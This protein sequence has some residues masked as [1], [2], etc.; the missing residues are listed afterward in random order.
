[1]TSFALTRGQDANAKIFIFG[2]AVFLSA[3]LIFSVQP[4]F[5]KVML[6]ALGGTPAVW[7]IAMVV[8]QGLLLAGYFY[9]HLLIRFLS[10]RL[11]ILVHIG[12]TCVAFVTLP[13][14]VTPDWGA[15]PQQGQAFWLIAI[16]IQ[17]IGLPFFALSAN[18][19]LL[20]AWLAANDRQINVYHLY[21]ASNIGSF[22]ALFAYPFIIEPF[23]GLHAQSLTWS[24]GFS[25][26]IVLLLVC[27]ALVWRRPPTP[28][29]R[30]AQGEP[31][32]L[33][34][35]FHW[36]LLAAVPSGLLIAATTHIQTDIS[37]GPI[38]W[39]LPLGIFL[40][41]FIFAFRDSG[42]NNVFWPRMVRASA[43]FAVAAA[44]VELHSFILVLG[45]AL[46]SVLSIS[47]ACHRALYQLRP[48]ESD[49]TEFYLFISLGGLV[50]G[51]FSALL[52]PHLFSWAAE[53]VLLILVGTLL[54]TLNQP[55]AVYNWR[56]MSCGA[57]LLV[58]LTSLAALTFDAN[59]AALV[60]AMAVTIVMLFGLFR[61]EI[62]PVVQGALAV[63]IVAIA[64]L[65]YDHDVQRGFFGVVRVKAD[66][67]NRFRM[68]WHGT[69]IH[70]VQSLTPINRT[71][72]LSYYSIDTAIGRSLTAMRQ[73]RQSA[74]TSIG[75]VGLGIGSMACHRRAGEHWTFFEIDPLI[76]AIARDPERFNF[77][78]ECGQSMPIIVGDARLTVQEQP[79]RAFDYLLI[80]AFSSD[81][82]PAHLITKEA[83]DMF[84]SRVTENG[85]LA[86]HISNRYINLAPVLAKIAD[87]KGLELFVLNTTESA[88]R[89][90]QM[91]YSTSAAAFSTG[92]ATAEALKA[93]GFVKMN[94]S[95]TQALWTDFYTNV[96]AEI[97]RTKINQLFFQ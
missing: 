56:H 21:A 9:A 83:V 74:A 36:L 33:A 73:V 8:F 40:L 66:A 41:T 70:G 59:R 65:P 57:L 58:F 29:T 27:V 77:L 84:L 18:A 23:V 92:P 20:Q 81:A 96:T 80:D 37:G 54:V 38:L 95:E 30:F 78:A 1:M 51:L 13:F 15:P 91:H 79:P 69:T 45:I 72:P 71:E 24:M 22:A 67:E 7:A 53:Y 10:L 31:L 2:T 4:I 62:K 50:G 44:I 82:I 32:S 11:A 39:L 19:P 63:A 97:V 87:V 68:L 14:A 93:R 16:F 60:A 64:V 25:F 55:H 52:A 43:I 46:L 90:V 86:F 28:E 35:R 75:I 34:R 76:I 61:Q 85:I 48:A 26:F 12:V 5:T 6:P 47:M 17:A 42:G 94:P 3:F 88:E 89:R 49:L